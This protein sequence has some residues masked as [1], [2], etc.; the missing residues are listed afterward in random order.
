MNQVMRREKLSSDAYSFVVVC[1]P[2]EDGLG[3]QTNVVLTQA[4]SGNT[5]KFAMYS[6]SVDGALNHMMSLTDDLCGQWF[7]ER[8]AKKK[9]D[10]K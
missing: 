10:A 2:R 9:K 4:S 6:A 7:N 5:K 8:Q 1:S 3:E